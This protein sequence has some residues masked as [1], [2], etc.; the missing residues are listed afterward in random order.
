MREAVTSH[1]NIAAFDAILETRAR[2]I[3][4]GGSE[5]YQHHHDELNI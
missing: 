4:Q 5:H 1:I 2:D 3:S